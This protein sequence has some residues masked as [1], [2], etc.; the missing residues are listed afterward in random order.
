[1]AIAHFASGDFEQSLQQART[2][3]QANPALPEGLIL[4]AAATAALGKTEE[5]RQITGQIVARWPAIH[6]GNVMPVYFPGF[7]R[8][9]DRVRLSTMLLKAGLPE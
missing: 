7:V 3:V 5:A 4:L 1:M 2:S 8:Q 6:I 9:E